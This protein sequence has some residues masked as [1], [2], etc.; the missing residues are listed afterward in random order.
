MDETSD[1]HGVQVTGPGPMISFGHTVQV[2]STALSALA[3]ATRRRAATGLFG[4]GAL[5]AV[6]GVLAL[7]GGSAVLIGLGVLA[8][9]VAAALG[10]AGWGVWHSIAVDAAE[11]ELD[12]AVE[13]AMAAHGG[14][15]S[16]GHDHDPEELHVTDACAHDGAGTQ[17]AHDCSTCVLGALRP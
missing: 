15:C 2:S 9:L 1:A 14:M 8:L 7:F 5:F 11:R 13:Y 16:C 6:V 17:C 3:P 4:F 10:L 12:A